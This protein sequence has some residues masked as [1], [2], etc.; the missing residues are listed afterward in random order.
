MLLGAGL[1]MV[2]RLIADEGL[3]AV[4]IRG[5]ESWYPWTE[6]GNGLRPGKETGYGQE[7]Q[8]REAPSQREPIMLRTLNRY[9]VRASGHVSRVCSSAITALLGEGIVKGRI[10]WMRLWMK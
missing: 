3:P 8:T 9:A 5:T 2:K 7:K 4:S 10:Q 1:T 6:C